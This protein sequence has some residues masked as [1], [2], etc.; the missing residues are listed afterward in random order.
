VDRSAFKRGAAGSA[1]T[2]RTERIL[3]YKLFERLRRVKG[4]YHPQQLAIKAPNERS[5]GP[6]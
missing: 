4:H 1:V 5:V 3:L 2:A 6:T